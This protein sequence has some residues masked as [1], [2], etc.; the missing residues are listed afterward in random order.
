MSDALPGGSRPEPGKIASV[1]LSVL[2]HAVLIGLLIY[3]IRWQSSPREAVQVELIESLPPMPARSAAKP[4]PVPTALSPRPEPKP[5]PKPEP[6]PEPKPPPKPDIAVKEKPPEKP[7]PEPKPVQ[8]PEP[9]PIAKPKPE[10]DPEPKPRPDPQRALMKEQ[11][12]R[13]DQTL[14]QNRAALQVEQ[15]MAAL[16]AQQAAGARDKSIADYQAK[17][18][19]KIRGNMVLPPSIAGNPEA[20]FEVTQ[21]PS[22]EVMS[23]RLKRSSGVTVLDEAIERAI[24]K[25]SPLPKP[26]RPELFQRSLEL[27]YKPLDE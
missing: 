8:K 23:V 27:K 12:A 6:K 19:G 14:A 10:P 3:G 21:L 1:G 7:K 2:M 26:D 25:S 18:R 22:G 13:E 16:R 24:R 9:K 11:L 17:V 15:E 5:A 4:D 20:V